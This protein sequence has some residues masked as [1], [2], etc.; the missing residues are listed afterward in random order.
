M[1][2]TILVDNGIRRIITLD[3]YA[4]LISGNDKR[5]WPELCCVVCDKLVHQNGFLVEN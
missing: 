5:D 2:T 3:E 1:E 4:N